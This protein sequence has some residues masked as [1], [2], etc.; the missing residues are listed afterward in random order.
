MSQKHG[1]SI[2][3]G[4]HSL[5]Q[6]VNVL[7]SQGFT[8]EYNFDLGY[9][10]DFT[11]KGAVVDSR[12]AK[13][14]W[15]FVARPGARQDGHKY[16]DKAYENGCRH[17]LVHQ[18][19]CIS[20]FL[21]ARAVFIAIEGS[22][23]AALFA[24]AK[25]YRRRLSQLYVLAISGSYGKTST[26]ELLG[27]ILAQRYRCA[28]TMGNRNAPVGCALTILGIA[29]ETEIAVLELGIDQPGEM[30]LLCSLAQPNG[31]L[32]TGIGSAHLA[33]FGSQEHL[34]C[35]KARIYAHL[36]SL[37][38]GYSGPFYQAE[39]LALLPED[40]DFIDLLRTEITGQEIPY[41]GTLMQ[42]QGYAV[43]DRGLKGLRFTVWRENHFAKQLTCDLPLL[44]LHTQKVFWAAASVAQILGLSVAEIFSGAQNY[45]PLFGRGELLQM[46]LKQEGY[47][48]TVG[49]LQDCYNASPRIFICF[50]RNASFLG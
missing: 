21:A 4:E 2:A 36:H 16:I 20:S 39:K 38:P 34:A 1:L 7:D 45:Q 32:L 12:E 8:P 18:S 23:E 3:A 40:D 11:V 31:A 24:W 41:S 30:D 28:I 50:D 13:K 42:Q 25:D 27:H 44:G 49:V 6:I 26:K 22:T 19:Y 5:R 29:P 33:G 47:G 9:C 35:Q 46:K 17:F 14:D 48:G 37:E 15:F 43:E 10:G